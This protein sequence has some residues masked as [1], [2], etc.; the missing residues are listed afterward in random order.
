MLK[1]YNVYFFLLLFL[2]FLTDNSDWF[3]HFDTSANFIFS[4]E[5]S[6]KLLE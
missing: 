5:V 6:L 4:S 2:N 3:S 1:K